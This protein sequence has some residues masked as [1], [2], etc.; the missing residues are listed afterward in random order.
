MILCHKCSGVLA[1]AK[2]EDGK[3][4]SCRCIS[5]YVRGFE[6]NLTLDE[7]ATQQAMRE[8]E[9]LALW[10][11][12]GREDEQHYKETLNR[13]RVA[14]KVSQAFGHGGVNWK[15]LVAAKEADDKH[16]RDLSKPT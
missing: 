3:L 5:G 1:C 4:N 16:W 7:A 6:P 10:V 8:I 13:L 14:M 11:S 12:Q 15:A 2:D 9:W